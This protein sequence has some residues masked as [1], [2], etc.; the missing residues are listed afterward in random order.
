MIIKHH[1]FDI[2]DFKST[3]ITLLIYYINTIYI[4]SIFCV[5][6]ES[7][8]VLSSSK[9]FKSFLFGIL[10]ASVTWSIS[11]YLYWKLTQSTDG[12]NATRRPSFQSSL[13]KA[14]IM[15][16]DILI[17]YEMDKNKIKRSKS[18]YFGD[19][20]YKNSDALKNH[21]KPQNIKPLVDVNKGNNCSFK[22]VI[23]YNVANKVITNEKGFMLAVQCRA[24][25]CFAGQLRLLVT[26]KINF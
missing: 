9:R 6:V 20:K 12:H 5:P 25:F 14:H 24:C 23:C 8:M 19:G 21:L 2:T 17:P 11:L 22:N 10:F 4:F 16:N 15:E 18:K 1:K 7:K 13:K 26:I 3:L